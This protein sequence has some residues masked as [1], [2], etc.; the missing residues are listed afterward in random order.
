MMIKELRE[1]RATLAADAAEILKQAHDDKRELLKPDEEERWQ[2]F[3]NE[4][5]ALKR[6][7]DM[8]EQQARLQQSLDEAQPRVTEP[9]QPESRSSGMAMRHLLKGQEDSTRA[10][11]LWLLA[12][13]TSGYAITAEDKSLAERVGVSLQAK[14]LDLSFSVDP[15][16]SLM[17]RQTWEYRAQSVGTPGAGGFT[18]PNEMMRALEVALLTYGG[19]RRAATVI[20]TSTGAALPIPTVNDTTQTGVILNENTQVTNQ[21]IAF[22]QLVLGAF[23]YSSKQVLVSVELMQDSSVNVGAMLGELLGIRIGRITNTHFTTGVGTTTPFG[24]VTQAAVGF[25]AANATSQ[26]TTWTYPSIVELEHSVDPAYRL[27]ASF[28]MA[29]SSLKK[30]KQLVDSQGRP[31]WMPSLAAGVPDT[32]LGYPVVINQDMA[33]MGVSAKS[34]LF[35][36]LSKYLIRDVLGV[37]LLRLE[38]RYADYH[39]IAFLAFA[40]M[41]GALLNAGTNPVKLFVNAAS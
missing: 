11:R 9:T 16:R 29:D 30:T 34:V 35:G 18:V 10:L 4:I 7:I 3:H 32:L 39:Q 38:E 37:T 33:P 41:D 25:T 8:Q 36:D 31:L 19:M 15:M 13:P 27:N 5:D 23:K 17:D 40:R 24:I 14:Q 12:S 20:R 6:H 21:D 26:V 28:M 2:A 22:S 1:K